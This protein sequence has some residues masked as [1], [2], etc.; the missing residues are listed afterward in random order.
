MYILNSALGTSE[1]SLLLSS[2]LSLN[3]LK[4]C[5]AVQQVYFPFRKYE[6]EQQILLIN[7]YIRNQVNRTDVKIGL[8][9]YHQVQ[10]QIK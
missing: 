8:P 10:V 3:C 7:S 5:L 6:A 1:L 9:F 2:F 4:V